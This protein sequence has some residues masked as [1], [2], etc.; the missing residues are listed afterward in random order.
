[1]SEVKI[2][3]QMQLRQ[4]TAAVH[5]AVRS[6]ELLER[7][8]GFGLRQSSGAFG[9]HGRHESGSPLALLDGVG[10][11]KSG[12]GLPQSRTLRVREGRPNGRQL[13][14]CASPLALL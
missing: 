2:V 13:L 5:D 9:R 6:R 11:A 4:R 3:W 1:M 8:P 7:P 12:R 10:G 14:D